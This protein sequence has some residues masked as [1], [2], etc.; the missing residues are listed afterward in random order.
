[1]SSPSA[2]A[3]RFRW[4]IV[5]LL[6]VINTVNYID[7]S[8]I[9]FAAQAIRQEFHL[10][11]SQLGLVLGAFGIG[12]LLTTFIGGYV[13][14]RFGARI[15]FAVAVAVWSLAI[16]WTGAATG[17]AI[18]YCARIV[19][20]L[21]EGPSFPAHARIVERWLPPEERAT[22]VGSALVAIPVALAVGAPLATYLIAEI[23]WRAMFFVLAAAGVLWLP[24]WL[25]FCS[26]FPRQ[27]RFVNQ[28]ERDHISGQNDIAQSANGETGTDWRFLLTTPTLVAG[29]WSYF[30][31]GYLLFFVM[32][33]LPEFLRTTYHLDLKQIGWAAAIPWA[34]AAVA[35]YGCGRLSD[36]LM[37]RT[38][39]LRIA[40][41]YLMAGLHGLVAIAVLPLAFVDNLPVALACMSVAVAAG[42]GANPMFYAVIADVAPRN[43]GTC[44]GIMNS[45][46]AASG[47]L[48][49][50]ITGF[51]LQ[52]T[53][54][55]AVAFAMISLFA[56]SSVIVLLVWH[57]PDRDAR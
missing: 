31:F 19:L 22:A 42:L 51:A 49:P 47:F 11:A 44:M 14:D 16:G 56:A 34:V 18:L 48:A 20:G 28:A 32:T 52:A 29:Y 10:S 2:T 38:G 54:S 21:A 26:D 30:V 45:G 7:R 5:L 35:L 41:S 3:S 37:T 23:G 43:A 27:S 46:L 17:F 25:Y 8:A 33:W 36:W 6:F 39:S 40:R 13:A 4:T 9:A 50:V 15:T 24:A 55:F 57:N 1:M 12:Y 53:G